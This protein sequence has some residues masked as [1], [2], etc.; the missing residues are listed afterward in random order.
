[1][2]EL[3]DYAKAFTDLARLVVSKGGHLNTSLKEFS[4]DKNISFLCDILGVSGEECI[5]DLLDEGEYLHL[6]SDVFINRKIEE[7]ENVLRLKWVPE[8]IQE[9][10]E[11]FCSLTLMVRDIIKDTKHYHHKPF[12]QII[13]NGLMTEADSEFLVKYVKVLGFSLDDRLKDLYAKIDELKKVDSRR[14]KLSVV[15]PYLLESSDFSYF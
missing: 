2:L 13:K 5:Q 7:L 4:E 12:R 14:S 3:V 15:N 9:S 10:Y 1:M 6:F 11:G 8:K